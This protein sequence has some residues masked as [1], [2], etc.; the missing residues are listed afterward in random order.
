M[1]LII[2]NAEAQLNPIMIENVIVTPTTK[3]KN[4]INA[5]MVIIRDLQA[6][7]A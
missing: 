7:P 6:N 1:E 4:V 2:K 5:K 3:E